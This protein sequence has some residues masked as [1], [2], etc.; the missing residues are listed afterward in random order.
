M[1]QV[2]MNPAAPQFGGLKDKAIQ[3]AQKVTQTRAGKIAATVVGVGFAY[4]SLKHGLPLLNPAH[5]LL[6]PIA[7][8]QDAVVTGLDA[9]GVY[10]SYQVA[11]GKMPFKKLGKVLKALVTKDEP[12]PNKS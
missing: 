7:S 3:G 8:S 11:R 9:A 12:K 4:E 6:N 1:V 5:D 10:G 2:G